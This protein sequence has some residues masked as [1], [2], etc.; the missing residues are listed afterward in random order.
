VANLQRQFEVF[1]ETIK[2]NY[3]IN[4]E[5]REKRDIILDKIEAS[6]SAKNRP[7]F[8]R[9]MQGSYIMRTGVKPVGDKEYDIDVGLRFEIK[10]SEYTAEE[11]RG[12]VFEAV[13]DH[14]ADVVA[15]GPCVRVHYAKGFHV[16]LVAYAWWQDALG[17]EQFRLAHESKGWLPADPPRLLKYVSDAQQAFNGTNGGTQTPQLRRVI[18]YLKRWDDVHQPDESDAKPSGLAFTLFVI[19]RLSRTVNWDGIPD[20]RRALLSLA[21]FAVGETRIIAKKPTPEYEDVFSKLN[22]VNMKALLG[23]FA[24][25]KDALVAAD[26]EPDLI[27]ACEGMVVIF[28]TD[29]PVPPPDA[30]SKKT[31]APAIITSSS[32]G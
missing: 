31:K 30:G 26:S 8:A 19:S 2:T 17:V 13:K 14:T 12:W 4:S 20:D 27:K 21:T 7:K 29:F 15:K 1:H 11:V 24:A 10:D 32:S 6:L 18:R 28:G 9:L 23:R 3:D 16:D 5:L 22:D 25:M